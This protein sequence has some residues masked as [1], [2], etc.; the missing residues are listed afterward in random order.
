[1]NQ[2]EMVLPIMLG[3]G[4]V[5]REATAVDAHPLAEFNA[6]IHGEDPEDAAMIY[7]W[8]EDLFSVR[9]NHPTT[10]PAHFTIVSDDSGQIISSLCTIPQ[11]W[12]YDDLPLNVGRIELVGTLPEYRGRGLVRQQMDYHHQTGEARGDL[13][14]VISGIPWYYRQFGY[15]MALDLGGGR[16]YVWERRENLKHLKEGDEPYTWRRATLNDLPLLQTLYAR[17]CAG[18]MINTIRTEAEWRHELLGHHEHSIQ[19]RHWWI[20]S[21]KSVGDVAYVQFAVWGQNFYVHEV[22]VV[23]GHSLRAV[24]LYLTRLFKGY[25]NLRREKVKEQPPLTGLLFRLGRH[26]PL[27]EAYGRQLERQ[28]QPYA[29][30]IRIPDL[31]RFLRHVQPVLEKRLAQSV[32]AGHTGTLRLN[33]Y[34]EGALALQFARGVLAGLEPYEKT[35][36]TD[37]DAHFPRLLFYQLLCG[38]ATLAELNETRADCYAD[39]EAEILLE[40]L[41]PKMISRPLGLG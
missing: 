22:A 2:D 40:I 11:T 9:H 15:D 6:K 27:Y 17:H 28:E 29:W 12:S 8:T 16:R 13:L 38:R 1:M 39:P 23:A 20:I 14:Q 37:G 25:A 4:L 21:E 7:H 10:T 19:F 18:S 24:G 3:D 35:S 32:M 33:F 41:F 5:L 30:Y 34:K 36:V 26:H 31:V